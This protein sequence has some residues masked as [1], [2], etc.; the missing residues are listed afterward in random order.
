MSYSQVDLV[1]KESDLEDPQSIAKCL[2]DWLIADINRRFERSQAWSE[3]CHFFAGNQWI[4]YVQYQHRFEQIPVTD[5]NRAIERPVTNYF[6]KWIVTNIAGFSN[7]PQ[8]VIDPVTDSPKDKTSS[9]I[10]EIVLDYL[11]EEHQKND[12]YYEAALWGVLCG[13][14][15]RK[16]VKIPSGKF[17]GDIPLYCVKPEVVSP[18]HIVFDGVPSRFKDI[19]VI[20]QTSIMRVSDVKKIFGVNKPGYYPDE[21]EKVEPEEISSIPLAI[22]EGLKN[23][24]PGETT[25]PFASSAGGNYLESVVLKE[26]YVAP[27]EKHPRGLMLVVAG[28]ATV[29]ASESPYYYL[30]GRF[31]HPYTMWGCIKMPGSIWSMGLGANLT[32]IQRRINS[33]DAVIAYNRKTMAVPIV[34]NPKGSG[35][36]AGI[37]IGQPGQVVDYQAGP[38]GEKPIRDQGIPLPPSVMQ[39]RESLLRDGSEIAMSADIR[40]GSNPEGVKTVGQLQILTEQSELSRSK[41]IESWESFIQESEYLDLLNFR[42]CYKDL[43]DPS[44]IEKLKG[45]AKEM[46]NFDWRQFKGS[47][48]QEHVNIRVEKGSTVNRSRLMRQDTIIKLA[49]AGLL[50][51]LMAGP[52]ER[53]RFLEE[54]GLTSMFSDANIDEK[55]AEKAIEMMLVGTYP[56]TIEGVHNPDV[57]L[58]VI[59]RYMKDPKYLEIPDDIKGLF[60]Q[61]RRE[62]TSLLSQAVQGQATGQIPPN[63]PQGQ[64]MPKPQ[65]K[66]MNPVGVT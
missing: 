3:A 56:P 34:W 4:K 31:W 36:P 42:D 10:S 2:T 37:F 13:P 52:Y 59:L 24:V 64:Q 54:F 43:A 6:A 51:E 29:Y 48:L 61:K 33:I 21:V 35:V 22:V 47:M 28:N 14:V 53:K 62:L 25:V 39:E 57:Q 38:N 9:Q 40:G 1:L 8:M 15:F 46:T 27:S 66:Q 65:A 63:V 17:Y 60:E 58:P 20:M 12:Q 18:F 26:C 55:M 49:T 23:I 45:F 5:A 44:M 32:K 7:R 16:S 19:G 11:W 41:Q 50:P 30:E